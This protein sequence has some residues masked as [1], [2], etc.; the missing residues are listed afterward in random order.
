MKN[1][2]R[3]W[4]LMSEAKRQSLIREVSTYFKVERDF[5]VGLLAAEEILNFFL[6]ALGPD[7]YNKGVSDSKNAVRQNLE[8]LEVD[9]DLLFNR[10]DNR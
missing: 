4:D 5:D 3:K 9:L 6:D 10:S 2:R 7:L 1:I 8:N